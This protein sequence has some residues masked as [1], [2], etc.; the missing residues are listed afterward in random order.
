MAS[1][2]DPGAQ[3]PDFDYLV[4]QLRHIGTPVEA[5]EDAVDAPLTG[6]CR[7]SG[8][9]IPEC[10]CATCTRELIMRYRPGASGS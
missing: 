9:T 5:M 3:D 1:D 8:L 2:L 6:R 10:S 4:M 7:H